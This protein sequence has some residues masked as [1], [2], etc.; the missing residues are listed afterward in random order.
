MNPEILHS[1]ED[2]SVNFIWRGEYPGMLEA[3]YVRRS[4]EYFVCYLSSQSG[5]KQACRFCHLTATK[6]TSL[7]DVPIADILNQASN[8]PTIDG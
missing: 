4:P 7:I 5:C 8:L 3:R 2:A 6:Q 1:Q